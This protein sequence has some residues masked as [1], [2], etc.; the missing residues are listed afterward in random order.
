MY[1]KLDKLRAEVERCKRRVEADKAKLKDAEERLKDAES[2]QILAEVNALNLT[3]EQ[4]A[5]FLKLVTSGKPIVKTLE[6]V[7]QKNADDNDPREDE[8][9]E[10]EDT[11]DEEN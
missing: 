10:S 5:D 9:D 3:P 11:E 6:S 8:Y 1:E 7:F 2:M 4:L